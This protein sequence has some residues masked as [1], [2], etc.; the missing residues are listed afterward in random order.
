[1]P[2][3]IYDPLTDYAE[4][5]APRFKEVCAETFADLAAEAK[6]DVDANR[7]T[8]AKLYDL[9]DR[10]SKVKNRFGN[11]KFLRALLWVLAALAVLYVIIEWNAMTETTLAA[12]SGGFTAAMA[13]QILLA[14]PKVRKLKTAKAGLEAEADAKEKEAWTQM[15]PLNDLYDWD[16]FSRMMT[17][18]VPR[19]EFDHFF[20]TQRLADLTQTYGWDGTFNRD[21]SVIY[22]HSGLINGNPFV[23]CRTRKMEMGQKSYTGTLT[24]SWTSREYGSDGKWHSVRHTQ[25]LTAT[26][27]APFPEYYEK[28]RLLYGNTAAPDLVF[29]RY[30]SGIA[31]HERSH[32]YRK[33]LREL[34]KKAR[35]LEHSDFAMLTNEEFEVAFDTRDRNDNQQFALLFTPLAQQA[36][37]RLLKDGTVGYGDDFDFHKSRMINM[38]VPG[39]MQDIDLDM[40]PGQFRD[41]DYDKAEEKFKTR[42]ANY[43]RAIY[44]SMAPLLCIPM[45]QQIRPRSAIY[46]TDMPRHSCFWEHEALANFWGEDRFKA[47]D[48]VTHCILKTEQEDQAGDSSR[49]VVHAYG[50]SRRQRLTMVPTWGGD[51]RMHN[52]P[53]YWDEYLPVEGVGGISMKEDNSDQPSDETQV[54]R[55]SHISTLLGDSNLTL[56]RRHIAS[57][58]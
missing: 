29:N 32:A 50:Y 44:F 27:T 30:H 24:I 25:V 43:F 34:R 17:K 37:L 15:E 3:N 41:F 31:G 8:C 16:I 6:V 38:V 39:H 2:E 53:V 4:K 56:Y 52:V 18:T 20:T 49:I 13:L 57:S 28:T 55:L 7:K 1:M 5:F 11:W 33:T 47:G 21:R 46:G 10:L 22:S 58:V 48:C 54:Q 51:G 9:R 19:L 45:Y 12:F 42:N 35:D 36:M 14:Y 23:I 26:V 40:D